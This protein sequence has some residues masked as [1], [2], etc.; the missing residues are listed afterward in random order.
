MTT[1]TRGSEPPSS[2]SPPS[3]WRLEMERMAGR[4][5]AREYLNRTPPQKSPQHRRVLG[6]KHT[7]TPARQPA[8]TQPVLPPHPMETLDEVPEPDPLPPADLV[9]PADPPPADPPDPNLDADLALAINQQERLDQGMSTTPR[10][11]TRSGRT[12]KPPETF[13]AGSSKAKGDPN[14]QQ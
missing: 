13:Q 4:E 12:T 3:P 14:R 1:P 5:H 8:G 11:T 2:I 9:V 7:S 10:L 6:P